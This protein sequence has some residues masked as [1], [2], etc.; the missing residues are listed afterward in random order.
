MGA[1]WKD[2]PE[3]WSKLIAQCNE[4]R[5]Q[6]MS[7]E[8]FE[9]LTKRIGHTSKWGKWERTSVAPCG[10]PAAARRHYSRKE[11]IDEACRLAVNSYNQALRK[12][13]KG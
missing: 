13:W 7:D 2:N 4:I 5:A 9:R 6:G 3:V 8:T 12:K 1:I 10:T 11:P